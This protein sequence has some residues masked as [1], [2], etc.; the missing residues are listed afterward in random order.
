MHEIACTDARRL[1]FYSDLL[2][3]CVEVG[4]LEQQAAWMLV[5]SR[6]RLVAVIVSYQDAGKLTPKY[7]QATIAALAEDIG[8]SMSNVYRA[9]QLA[10]HFHTESDLARFW[11]ECQQKGIRPSLTYIKNNVL[12]DPH[13]RPEAYGGRANVADELMARVESLTI[14]IEQLHDILHDASLDIDKRREVA[15]VL[16][17][18]QAIAHEAATALVPQDSGDERSDTYLAYI[19]TLG[20]I[21]CDMP[22][23]PHH[24]DTGGIGMKGSDY[25]T[26]PL[27]RRHH[28][29]AGQNKV[30]FE[31]WYGIGLDR[32]VI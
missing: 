4:R 12:P 13:R 11:E 2:R 26:V 14:G 16:L 18:T 21:I 15:G 31:R 1:P 29:E 5:L 22:A 6:Y 28:D 3:E 19:R 23:E 8:I 10:R 9:I 20:C 30:N 25:L 7:G 17:K 24:I 32:E 27:C